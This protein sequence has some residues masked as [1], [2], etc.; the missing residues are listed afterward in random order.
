M[1]NERLPRVEHYW[2]PGPVDLDMECAELFVDILSSDCSL[3]SVK[4]DNQTQSYYTSGL[5]E[6]YTAHYGKGDAP[7]LRISQSWQSQFQ[8]RSATKSIATR[9]PRPL[10]NIES[11]RW[12]LVNLSPIR[13]TITIS[14]SLGRVCTPPS[15]NQPLKKVSSKSIC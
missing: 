2:S 5:F 4:V 6:P 15:S 12:K 10:T 13:L 9:K 1:N 7:S 14:I 11:T 3:S 8:M